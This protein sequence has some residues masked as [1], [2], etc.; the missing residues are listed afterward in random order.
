MGWIRVNADLLHERTL[1]EL[2]AKEFRSG[3]LAAANGDDNAFAAFVQP[4][5]NRPSPGVW[6]ALRDST[7]ERD[8]YTCRYCGASD[9]PLEC[10]HV[11]PLARGGSNEPDNLVTA[12]RTCNRAKHD[13]TPEEWQA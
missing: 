10:D 3:F 5:N 4:C 11:K 6:K 9:V 13:K 1:Q 12:C 2:S 7:F 8:G